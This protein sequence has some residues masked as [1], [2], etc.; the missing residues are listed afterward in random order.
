MTGSSSRAYGDSRVLLLAGAWFT[1][2]DGL[3]PMTLQAYRDWLDHQ[4][5][6]RL[7]Q[8]RIRELSVGILDRHLRDI[9]DHHGMATA[10]MC[11]SVL[12]GMCALAARDA[13]LP[14]NPVRD[15]G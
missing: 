6:P 13:R 10:R 7:G 9:A 15:L 2:L 14:H 11:R 4:L 5:S 3:S 8:L 1:G 12:S